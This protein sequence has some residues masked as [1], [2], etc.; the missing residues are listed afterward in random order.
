MK[1]VNIVF[2]FLLG[3]ILCLMIINIVNSF[4]EESIFNIFISVI[5][6]SFLVIASMNIS[7]Y[8]NTKTAVFNTNNFLD[9]VPLLGGLLLAGVVLRVFFPEIL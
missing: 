4:D 6:I 1:I 3:F 5:T 7:K 8:I 9:V 2:Q